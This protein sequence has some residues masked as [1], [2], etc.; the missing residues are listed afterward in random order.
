MG[1]AIGIALVLKRQARRA[2]LGLP[3]EGSL[4]IG[5]KLGAIVLA[6]AFCAVIYQDGVPVPVVIAALAAA[7]GAIVLR[8]TRLGR[9]AFAIG[10]NAEAARLSG[11]PV[12]R[13][14]MSIYIAIGVLT[15]LAGMVG[16]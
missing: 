2:S 11:V 14:T 10:G 4:L 5:L 1:L 6:A 13:V 12:A 8:R 9:Y 16:A 15:A 3:T 7:A